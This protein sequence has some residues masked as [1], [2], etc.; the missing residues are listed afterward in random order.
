MRRGVATTEDPVLRLWVD[1]VACDG[2]GQ[3]ALAA[4][5]LVTL[6]RW[7][8]PVLAAGA[9]AEDPA[10]TRR[11]VA[12]CPRRALWLWAETPSDERRSR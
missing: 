6:D 8:Y 9:A 1:P 11:A 12:A 7:G 4:P 5:E 3:C 2:I 10:A